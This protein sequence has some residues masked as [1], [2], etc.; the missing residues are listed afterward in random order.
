MHFFPLLEFSFKHKQYFMGHDVWR[1]P[2]Q[3]INRLGELSQGNLC[4]E[5]ADTVNRVQAIINSSDD[6]VW[7]I[8]DQVMG[9]HSNTMAEQLLKG[10]KFRSLVHER[11]AGSSLSQVGTN[12]ERRVL[13][14]IPGIFAITEKE[15]FVELLTMDGK[16]DGIGFFW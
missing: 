14:S 8:T 3:F 2:E 16:L 6:H 9:V 1:L 7:I 13:S 4:T 5:L 10:V 15:A 12:V 11:L